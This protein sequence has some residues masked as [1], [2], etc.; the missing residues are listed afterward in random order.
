LVD[1][2]HSFGVR[3]FGI[4]GGEPLM[5]KDIFDIVRYAKIKLRFVS[6]RLGKKHIGRMG[7][8]VAS[9]LQT[10]FRGTEIE[11]IAKSFLG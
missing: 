7:K 5:R 10:I 9:I 6:Y 1:E 4:K 8:F 2:V 11:Y 3:W